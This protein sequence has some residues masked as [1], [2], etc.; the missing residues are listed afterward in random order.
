MPTVT[1]HEAFGDLCAAAGIQGLEL[2]CDTDPLSGY[3]EVQKILEKNP[4]ITAFAVSR[5]VGTSF[6]PQITAFEIDID[7]IMKKAVCEL[8][9][10]INNSPGRKAGILLCCD[11][12]E[13]QSTAPGPAR[14]GI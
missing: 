10:R 6:L 11:L 8:I 7:T 13:R 9:G 12:V 2:F 4:G 14:E 1:C 5:P 3:R